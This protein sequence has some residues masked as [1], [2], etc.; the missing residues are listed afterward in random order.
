MRVLECDCGHRLEAP[1]DEEL[2]A[3]VR[4]HVE[5]SHPDMQL[6]DE[7]VRRLV[8]DRAYTQDPEDLKID[9]TAGST[10]A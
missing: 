6:G 2:T 7:Q 4:E 9:P 5:Q 1:N 8:S 3:R 10:G